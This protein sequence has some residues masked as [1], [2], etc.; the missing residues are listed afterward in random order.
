VLLLE[1]TLFAA[2]ILF[3]SVYVLVVSRFVSSFSVSVGWAVGRAHGFGP[4]FAQKTDVHG[5]PVALVFISGVSS[6]IAGETTLALNICASILV[7]QV[8]STQSLVGFHPV[9]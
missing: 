6:A 1:N 3:S 9:C 8:R 2:D 7:F 5:S 4:L